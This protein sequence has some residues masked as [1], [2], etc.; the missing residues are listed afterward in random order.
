MCALL[1]VRALGCRVPHVRSRRLG[2]PMDTL[3]GNVLGSI[4]VLA[5]RGLLDGAG[6]D[7]LEHLAKSAAGDV[8]VEAAFADVSRGACGA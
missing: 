2:V 4:G 6:V 1:I 3:Q 5:A 8:A 7:Y